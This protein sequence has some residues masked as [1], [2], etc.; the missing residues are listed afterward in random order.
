MWAVPRDND[1]LLNKQQTPLVELKRNPWL[2]LALSAWASNTFA[3]CFLWRGA[4]ALHPLPPRPPDSAGPSSVCFVS[5]RI[6]CDGNSSLSAADSSAVGGGGR[7]P[8]RPSGWE[9]TP[10]DAATSVVLPRRA[11]ASPYWVCMEAAVAL[12]QLLC[13]VTPTDPGV[14]GAMQKQPNAVPM[15]R[16]NSTTLQHDATLLCVRPSCFPTS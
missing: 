8:V 14:V 9:H 4:T 1:I 16:C 6:G 7:G 3:V 15:G 10:S 5:R 2:R 12:P 11:V 13:S